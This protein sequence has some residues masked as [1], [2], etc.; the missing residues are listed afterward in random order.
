MKAIVCTKYGTPDV[1][2]LKEVDLPTPKDEDVR[3]RIH[4]AIVTPSDCAFRKAD[5]FMVRFL[6]GLRRPKYA[7]LGVELSGEI[8]SIGK[9]VTLFKEGDPLAIKPANMTYE[10]AVGVCDGALTALIFLRDTAKIQRGQ[11]V[12]INGASGSVGAYAV[13][14]A[15]IFGAE[16][17]GVCSTTNL[18][19]VKSL[20]ADRVI[21]YTT[22]DF[23]KNG[24]TYDVIFNAVGK[25][26]YSRC[27]SSLTHSGVYLTTSPTLGIMLQMLWTSKIG[28]KK[29]MFTAAGLKQNKENLVF[30]RELVEAGKL[31]SVIDKRFP[32]SLCAEA[33]TYVEQGHKKGNVTLILEHA[34]T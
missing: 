19:L 16:V 28:S 18:D 22:E 17:T 8:E 29:A 27:K 3:I 20:G 26:S 30:L 9:H 10:E 5:P 24:L 7:I 33:H 34:S 11:K 1:L 6:Y 13:Q 25:N 14:L 32:L 12:L 2:Q 21:D 15:K 23:T 31:K 4:A